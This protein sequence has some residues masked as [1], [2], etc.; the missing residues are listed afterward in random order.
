MAAEIID[1]R[2]IAAEIREELLPEIKSLAAKGVVPGLSVILV[3]D[4]PASTAYVRMKEKACQEVGIRSR[5]FRFPP[6][7]SQKTLLDLIA[8]LTQDQE[9]HGILV[10]LP[11]PKQIDENTILKA[12]PPWKDVDGFH[13]ENRGKLATGEDTFIPCTPAGVQELLLRSG[14]RPEGK[15][16]VIVGRSNIVGRPLANLLTQKKP[17]ANATVTLCHTGTSNLDR[18]TKQA[19]ILIAAMGRAQSI[20][21]DM[22]SPGVVIIDVGVNRVEDPKSEKGYRLVGDVEFS[23]ASLIARAI[24]P[25][26]GGVGPMTIVMLLKN[27]IKAAKM[28]S[29]IGI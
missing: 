28:A 22:V 1:G 10:Q 3:G 27:T 29:H 8:D 21:G 2:K 6:D 13:P 20:T 17:G 25:V 9:T 5:T 24:S 11:L 4:H 12:L 15:H 19:E 16:V 14:H 26:P 7:V 23:S 18:F